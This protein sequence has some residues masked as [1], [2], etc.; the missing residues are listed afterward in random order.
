MGSGAAETPAQQLRA[1]TPEKMETQSPQ[2]HQRS[3]KLKNS[4]ER[5]EAPGHLH[6]P[7]VG[8]KDPM[9]V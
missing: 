7:R 8:G 3:S 9:I 4:S 6:Y 5:I 1:R 2:P